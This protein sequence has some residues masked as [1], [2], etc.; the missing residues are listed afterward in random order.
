MPPAALV[1]RIAVLIAGMLTPG[2][3]LMIPST[4][5]FTPLTRV[6]CAQA[7][8]P[9]HAIEIVTS[10]PMEPHA[11]RGLIEVTARGGDA[12]ATSEALALIR[13]KA[14]A[15]GCHAARIASIGVKAGQHFHFYNDPVLDLLDVMVTDPIDRKLVTASCLVYRDAACMAE[16]RAPARRHATATASPPRM[17]DPRRAEMLTGSGRMS[18]NS[19]WWLASAGN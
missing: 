6:T 4:A 11:E 5:E 3:A 1:R 17:C 2:C 13:E 9:A 12:T 15:N 7:A 8:R 16:L 14:A 10:P 19:P 18:G